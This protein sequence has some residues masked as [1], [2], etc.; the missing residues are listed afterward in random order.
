[1]R[2]LTVIL[3]LIIIGLYFYT[4]ATKEVLKTTGNAVKA[5]GKGAVEEIKENPDVQQ[6]W[7]DVKNK[8]ATRVT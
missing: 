8:T 6:A 7:K 5:A 4:D 1:M 3:L 2:F